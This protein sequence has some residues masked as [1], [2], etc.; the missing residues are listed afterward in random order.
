MND[1]LLAAGFAL[2]TASMSSAFS[3]IARRGQRHGTALTGVVIGLIVSVPW[4]AALTVLA[5]EPAWWSAEAWFWFF[6]S[7]V[8]GP[9]IGRVFMFRAIHRLGVSRAIP[10]LAANPLFS[11]GFAFVF[12]GERPGVWVWAGILLVVFGCAGITWRRKS[13]AP[14]DRRAVWLPLVAVLG[15]SASN[16]FRKI[17]IDLVPS[18]LLGI[19]LTSAFGLAALLVLVGFL[20]RAQRPSLGRGRAWSFYGPCGIINTLA[21]LSH[22]AALK[23]GDVSVVSP[24]S[25]TAPLFALLFAWMFLRDVERITPPILLGTLS[26]VAGGALIA[27]KAI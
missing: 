2:G 14:W 13:D 18:A 25:S 7:G 15:F 10:L 17:G 24:L 23:Y 12:L 3:L 6:L 8:T 22:F 1:A 4:L 19:T 11:A 20:P 5:W 16:I 26:V 27:L 9:A 21:F